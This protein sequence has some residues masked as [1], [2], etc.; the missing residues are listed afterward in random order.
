M[1]QVDKGAWDE[2]AEAEANR[3][4]RDVVGIQLVQHVKYGLNLEVLRYGN[5]IYHMGENSGF[6]PH[7]S[8]WFTEQALAEQLGCTVT[9]VHHAVTRLRVEKPQHITED[10]YVDTYRNILYQNKL[11]LQWHYLPK[12]LEDLAQRRP[13]LNLAR[14][15]Y[16]QY[17]D[18]ESYGRKKLY[19]GRQGVSK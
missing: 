2:V 5:V 18:T 12:L 8:Y 4:Y 17:L 13:Y 7:Y 9:R 14:E 15:A 10:A 1:F 3:Q 6:R 19:F 16:Q 11:Y